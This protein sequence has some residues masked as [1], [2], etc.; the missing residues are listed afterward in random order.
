VLFRNQSQVAQWVWDEFFPSGAPLTPLERV[1]LADDLLDR[2]EEPGNNGRLDFERFSA[3]YGRPPSLG[4]RSMV[5][6]LCATALT[7]RCRAVPDNLCTCRYGDARD[8]LV[9]IRN[10]REQQ[11]TSLNSS[12]HSSK[13]GTPTPRAGFR[14]SSPLP[15]SAASQIGGEKRGEAVVVSGADG[16]GGEG[17]GGGVGG[18]AGAEGRRKHGKMNLIVP[19]LN[20]GAAEQYRQDGE[21]G[22]PY[23]QPAFVEQTYDQKHEYHHHH[24]SGRE[25]VEQET[26]LKPAALFAESP[27]ETS[28]ES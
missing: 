3:W 28:A 4:P 12:A 8:Q 24:H 19:K 10:V 9:R 6:D 18:G 17:G 20:L 1:K 2:C 23:Q 15:A 16:E 13:S 11:V 21:A 26:A 14:S 27:G 22:Q 5:L 7:Q 25:E